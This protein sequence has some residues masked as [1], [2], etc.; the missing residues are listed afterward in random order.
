VGTSKTKGTKSSGGI[1]VYLR[2]PEKKKPTMRWAP[3]RKRKKRK[4]NPLLSTATSGVL[5][6]K[7]PFT[8]RSGEEGTNVKKKEEKN[9]DP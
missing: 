2:A 6:A 4:T 5:I 8:I 3:R 7:G 9:R 1:W